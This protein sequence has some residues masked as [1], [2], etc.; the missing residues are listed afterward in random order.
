[1]IK[2]KD[3]LEDKHALYGF[4]ILQ[5]TNLEGM[6]QE[7]GVGPCSDVQHTIT[8]QVMHAQNDEDCGA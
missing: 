2:G 3:M 5:Q 8:N 7:A 4:D 6:Q 1:M